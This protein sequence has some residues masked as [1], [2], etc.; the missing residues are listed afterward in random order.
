MQHYVFVIINFIILIILLVIDKKR[1]KDYIS[2]GLLAMFLD[3]I[4]EQIPIRAG[5]WIYNSEPKIFGFSFYMWILYFPY[6]S[7][8]YFL[9]NKLVKSHD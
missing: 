3:L 5:F 8:C 4:F 6:I 9:G 2:L 7:I 1:I